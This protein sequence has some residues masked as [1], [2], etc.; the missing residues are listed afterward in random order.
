MI[1]GKHPQRREFAH[2]PKTLAEQQSEYLLKTL[3][4][5]KPRELAEALLKF[6]LGFDYRAE[7]GP[8]FEKISALLEKSG[9]IPYE[10][11]IFILTI[12]MEKEAKVVAKE[13]NLQP[14]QVIDN[15]GKS[16]TKLY[17][18]AGKLAKEGKGHIE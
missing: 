4:S 8:N 13:L 16:L 18:H 15:L 3:N 14:Q 17:Q 6:C 9:L 11:H 7:S 10:Q 2:H 12:L 5:A 1:Y